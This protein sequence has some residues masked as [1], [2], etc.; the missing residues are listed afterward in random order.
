MSSNVV[1]PVV[2]LLFVARCT[3]YEVTVPPV[4]AFQ[5][6]E[7]PPA[8]AV[9]VRFVGALQSVVTANSS[10]ELSCPAELTDETLYQ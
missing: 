9:P 1:N 3:R 5:D 2:K 10:V 8:L 4:G 6:R 7:M